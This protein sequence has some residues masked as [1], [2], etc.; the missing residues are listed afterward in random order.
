M[1]EKGANGGGSVNCT[2]G[3]LNVGGNEEFVRGGKGHGAKVVDHTVSAAF[4]KG[5]ILERPHCIDDI[6]FGNIK[7]NASGEFEEHFK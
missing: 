4:K 3:V 1:H 5:A 2:K 6:G 7:D